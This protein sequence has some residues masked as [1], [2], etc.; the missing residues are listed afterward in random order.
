MVKVKTSIAIIIITFFVQ[1]CFDGNSTPPNKLSLSANELIVKM[2]EAINITKLND[3]KSFSCTMSV[4]IPASNSNSKYE[5]TTMDNKVFYKLS[6]GNCKIGYDGF[7]AWHKN[8][9]TPSKK[10]SESEQEALGQESLAAWKSLISYYDSVRLG[11]FEEFEGRQCF[12][13]ICKNK[14][15]GVSDKKIFVDP[16]TYLIVGTKE[17]RIEFLEKPEKPYE[18][19]VKRFY[20][21]YKKAENGIS[22]CDSIMEYTAVI[23]PRTGK[24]SFNSS[25]ETEYSNQVK[26]YSLLDVKFNL[27]FAESLFRDPK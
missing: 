27:P 26:I 22:Y 9:N 21:S 19:N 17:K 1:S 10:L 3:I 18:V 4:N 16:D 24:E 6:V 23:N 5:F 14:K 15:V 7:V 13:L 20:N 8:A 12:V 11:D 25:G 2:G